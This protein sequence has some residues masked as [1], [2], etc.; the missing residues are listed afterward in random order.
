M[1]TVT[2][3][4]DYHL[5]NSTRSAGPLRDRPAGRDRPPDTRRPRTFD[6]ARDLQAETG[7]AALVHEALASSRRPSS[8]RAR[9]RIEQ[10]LHELRRARDEARDLRAQLRARTES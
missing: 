3:D 4:D 5:V 8:W 7:T 6:Y 9:V 1:D 10:L 2:I